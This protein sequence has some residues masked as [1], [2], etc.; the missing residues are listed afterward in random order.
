M[1]VLRHEL[2]N[3]TC[4]LTDKEVTRAKTQLKSQLLMGLE[5]TSSRCEQLA[6]HMLIYGRP[7]SLTE[8]VERIEAVSPDDLAN[9][10]HNILSTTPTL[11]ALGPIADAKALEDFQKGF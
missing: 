7:L 9:C 1:P 2:R 8:L 3:I 11:T 5:N 10:A 4:D 6:H